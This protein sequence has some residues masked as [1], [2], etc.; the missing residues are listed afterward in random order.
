MQGFTAYN[1]LLT[2][3]IWLDQAFAHCPRFLTAAAIKRL[4]RVSVPMWPIILSDQLR[5]I[6]L[7]G[8][9]LTNN[10]I[11]R[12]RILQHIHIIKKS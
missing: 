5:I 8:F 7:V 3:V 6:G 4:D 11:L 10:L 9:C 12:K 1:A 2:Q